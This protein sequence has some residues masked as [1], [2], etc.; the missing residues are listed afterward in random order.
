MIWVLE[1]HQIFVHKVQRTSS[2]NQVNID[3][4]FIDQVNT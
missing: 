4:V 1:N 2:I 3:L